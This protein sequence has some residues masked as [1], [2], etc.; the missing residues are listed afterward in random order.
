MPR[1]SNNISSGNLAIG[2]SV[3]QSLSH[4]PGDVVRWRCIFVSTGGQLRTAG[5]CDRKPIQVGFSKVV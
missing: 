1:L 5:A 3:D 4:K 2:A